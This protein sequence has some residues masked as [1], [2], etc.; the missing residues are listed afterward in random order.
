MH[1]SGWHH[2]TINGKRAGHGVRHLPA[3]FLP[4]SIVFRHRHCRHTCASL[5]KL[6]PRT[7]N[8]SCAS[9]APSRLA[10]NC[11]LQVHEIG[12]WRSV[13]WQCLL[14]TIGRGW[15]CF[16]GQTPC[17]VFIAVTQLLFFFLLVC[18]FSPRTHTL[19]I[20]CFLITV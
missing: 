11:A 9:T 19:P 15:H 14:P 2:W 6:V 20:S 8:E 10:K 12:R 3:E 4:R 13:H 16:H 1:G 17:T 18:L 7:T 5:W